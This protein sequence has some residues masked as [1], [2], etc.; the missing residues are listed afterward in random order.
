MSC[1]NWS[2][3]RRRVVGMCKALRRRGIIARIA[4]R[5]RQAQLDRCRSCVIGRWSRHCEAS[6]AAL[7]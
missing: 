3:L 5:R 7:A 4:Q 2:K 1:W 6:A